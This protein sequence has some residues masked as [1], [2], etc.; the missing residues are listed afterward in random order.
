MTTFSEAIQ[1]LGNTQG[2][3][4]VRISNQLIRLLSEQ[5][6]SSPIK[7]IEELVVNA[8][9][10]DANECRIG[11]IHQDLREDSAIVI[12][13]NGSGMDYTGLEHLWFVG[14]S[15]KTF[16]SRTPKH[17]RRVIGKFGIGK[18][19][20]CAIAN[21]IT[22]L[23][24]HENGLF[25]VS[26]DFRDF[27]SSTSGGASEAVALEVRQV[28][29]LEEL[30]SSDELDR[31]CKAIRT[32]TDELT[33]DSYESWTICVL[34]SLKKQSENLKRKRL[35]WVIKTAMP[36][37]MNFEVFVDGER[38][39][40]TKEDF[41]PIVE[42]P[43]V[44]IAAERLDIMNKNLPEGHTWRVADN[45]FVSDLF[46]NG[47]TGEV[48]LTKKSLKAGKSVDIGRS[49]GFFV[50]VRERLVNQDD[51]LF[52]L[53]AL[54]HA[55]FNYFRADVFVDDLHSDIT[56]SRE[57][58]EHG[59]RRKAISDLLLALFNVARQRHKE[60]ENNL[61][62]E[63]KRK[64]EHERS[65]VSHR[66]VAQ[67]IADTIAVATSEEA[68]TDA[69]EGW[70]FLKDIDPSSRNQIV[71]HL[72]TREK[73]S[74]K[75][76]YGQ[77]GPSERMVKFDPERETFMLN[78]DHEVV[79]AHSDDSRARNLLE[80]IVASEVMLEVYLRE[81][82]INP[83]V[84]G[85][86]LERRDFLL[87]SLAQAG[88]YSLDSLAQLLTDARDDEH[89]LEI[90]VVAAARALGFNAKH[91]SGS[92]QP[93]GLARFNDYGKGEVKITLEA[94]SSKRTPSLGSF[95]FAGLLEHKQQSEAVGCLLV[96]PSYP[97]ELKESK[98]SDKIPDT[99]VECRARENKISCWTI[100]DLVKVIRATESHQIT[101]VQVLD[102]VLNRF[103]PK[104]VKEA[105]EEL[106]QTDD[107][108][109][110]YQ[111]ILNA[112][113]RLSAPGVLKQSPRTVHHISTAMTLESELTEVTD[114]KVRNAL[115]NLSNASKGMVRMSGNRIIFSGDIEEFARR[116]A[117]L[118]G[119]DVTPRK[120]GNFRKN[121]S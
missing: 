32:S 56:A 55:T 115:V 94:K 46:P 113:R 114:K 62:I 54:S 42:F 88:V 72:Y 66:L 44:D 37:K 45:H 9:D 77:L 23:T 41:H 13:D 5:M 98:N 119:E 116:V 82:G 36:L 120:L 49:H 83:F 71:E 90:A 7:A 43:I 50:F 10:A 28:S 121:E 76:T 30:R 96:A 85:E 27:E 80:D 3:L 12:F 118:T 112:L 73:R 18:L 8:Y 20:T 34:E 69:D 91:I 21:K 97:G 79:M 29:D 40:R 57:G 101:A 39:E 78:E 17:N 16:N 31:V 107:M 19:A 6:Y 99:A 1:T 104:E 22:Y 81:A 108:K 67:P 87:R 52:G 103:T 2:S 51:E 24:S 38:I 58:I 86:V 105:V 117:S 63:E 15:P 109:T 53:H 93:D 111:E 89:D 95:D 60:Y 102:I 33:S 110:Y 70:F 47:V 35:M 75:F 11:F 61:E 92:G 68:G 25:L 84:I 65:F 106:L 14:E 100:E 59:E 74:Y 48:L 4:P 64:K 26:C